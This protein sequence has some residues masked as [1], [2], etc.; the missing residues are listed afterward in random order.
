MILDY[1]IRLYHLHLLRINF[2]A[3]I[4]RFP[5]FLHCILRYIGFHWNIM[6]SGIIFKGSLHLLFIFIIFSILLSLFHTWINSRRF[7]GKRLSAKLFCFV[8]RFY[9]VIGINR[10]GHRVTDLLIMDIFGFR[11]HVIQIRK[12]KIVRGYLCAFF[13]WKQV[14]WN[15]KFLCS[16]NFDFNK[17]LIQ[18]FMGDL[19]DPIVTIGGVV[20]KNVWI[21]CIRQLFFLGRFVNITHTTG[22]ISHFLSYA[23]NNK[24]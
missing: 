18:R 6:I 19:L 12:I 14:W 10:S 1:Y 21:P 22:L 20:N 16:Q 5:P 9:W 15:Y 24:I 4:R 23:I 8:F 17:W 2:L 7:G 3:N 11:F 13:L